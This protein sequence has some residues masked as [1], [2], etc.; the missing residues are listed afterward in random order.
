MFSGDDLGRRSDTGA[1]DYLKGTAKADTI[2]GMGGDDALHG[3]GDNDTHHGDGGND[4]L[5]GGPGDD[6]LRGGAGDDLAEERR[7]F[8]GSGIDTVMRNGSEQI[9]RY[10]GCERFAG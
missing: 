5:Y 6:T 10:A 8:G 9:D 3:L 4:G 2:R 1:G 7:V